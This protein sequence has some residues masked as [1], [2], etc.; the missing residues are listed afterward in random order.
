MRMGRIY[1]TPYPQLAIVFI[2]VAATI[3]FF[4]PGCMS[5]DVIYSWNEALFEKDRTY[6]D[7]QPTLVAYV[8]YLLNSLPVHPTPQYANF[9]LFSTLLFWTGIVLA[10]EQ[11][12]NDKLAWLIFCLG[13]GFFPPVFAILS[14]APLKDAILC[15]ALIAAYG[16]LVVAEYRRSF[17]SFFFSVACL[18]LALGFRHN[19]VFAV[20][21]LALW[22][23]CVL[24]EHLLLIRGYFGKIGNQLTSGM[25]I[26]AFLAL[27]FHFA[28]KALTKAPTFPV[29]QIFVFDLVGMSVKA[30]KIYLP[31]LFED[32]E[33]PPVPFYGVKGADVRENPLT[34]A[35]LRKLYS[36]E[37]VLGIYWYGE[38]KGLR[39]LDNREELGELESAWLAA[40][41]ENPADYLQVRLDMFLH[42]F[43]IK[44]AHSWVYYCM[45]PEHSRMHEGIVSTTLPGYYLRHANSIEYRPVFY[46]LAAMIFVFALIIG[47]RRLPRHIVLLV[48]RTLLPR[49]LFFLAASGL[50]YAAA[51]AV[52]A[53]DSSFRFLYWLVV[54]GNLMFLN[55]A[56]F[57]LD[58]IR[59]WRRLKSP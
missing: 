4:Y 10:A 56:L 55:L 35:N 22:A 5:G 42:L 30:G 24:C 37:S 19:A 21:P 13:G 34:L 43:R 6:Y 54:V 7:I 46:F 12:I 52:I 23:G 11:W 33:R 38:G 40:I 58:A 29:Q 28:N 32:Y 36:P 14:Q 49:Q 44:Q 8:W 20:A 26:F 3:W 25:L 39:F 57:A 51:Y 48:G 45:L 41:R 15:A 9:F 17:L 31:K 2:G 59:I 50:L 18:F 53:P 1:R 47:R 16:G 27:G